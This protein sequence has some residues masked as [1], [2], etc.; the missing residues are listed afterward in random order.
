VVRIAR[1]GDATHDGGVA[2]EIA[3]CE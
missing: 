1:A 2:R 3:A